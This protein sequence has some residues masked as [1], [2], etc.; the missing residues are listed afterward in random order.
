MNNRYNIHYKT[1]PKN[2]CLQV[3]YYVNKPFTHF[4]INTSQFIILK[5]V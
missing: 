2:N 4:T 3:A 5:A 1:S